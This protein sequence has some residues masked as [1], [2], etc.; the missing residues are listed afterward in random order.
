MVQQT[1][2]RDGGRTLDQLAAFEAG[3]GGREERGVCDG[4][5]PLLG[6]FDELDAVPEWTPGS[7]VDV[8]GSTGAAT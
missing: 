2:C 4:P 8:G 6:G 3:P 5:T 1:L 7:Q